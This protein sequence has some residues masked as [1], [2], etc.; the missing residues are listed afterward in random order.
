M[1]AITDPLL[2]GVGKDMT[3]AEAEGKE[4]WADYK[5]MLKEPTVK[6]L[7]PGRSLRKRAPRLKFKTKLQAH[8]QL[9]SHLPHRNR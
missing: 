3:E 7:I 6:L 4:A 9:R 8:V 2:R 1:I 5:A